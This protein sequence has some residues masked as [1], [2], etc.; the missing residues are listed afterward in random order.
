MSAWTGYCKD[1][2][3]GSP[4]IDG[5]AIYGLDGSAWGYHN[6]NLSQAEA[7]KIAAGF[8]NPASITGTGIFVA[9][10]KYMTNKAT[11]TEIVAR[12]AKVGGCVIQKAK[13]CFVLG[14]F[15]EGK[16]PGT[17]NNAVFKFTE[18]LIG[19]NM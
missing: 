8:S 18:W 16:D 5:A 3:C 17:A 14:Q 19:Q 13:T 4:H 6:V 7:K 11:D 9:G 12:K 1:N 2:L 15:Q 10:Q